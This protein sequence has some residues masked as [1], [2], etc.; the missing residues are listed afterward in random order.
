M[1]TFKVGDKV[2][3]TA[4]KPLP[5]R[6]EKD[7]FKPQIIKFADHPYYEFESKDPD[8]GYWSVNVDMGDKLFLYK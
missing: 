5:E 7:L 4:R 3:A 6:M 8:L 2:W 1:K